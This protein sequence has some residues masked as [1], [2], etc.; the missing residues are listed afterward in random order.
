MIT[1][2]FLNV[3]IK[4]KRITHIFYLSWFRTVFVLPVQQIIFILDIFYLYLD[5]YLII[6]QLTLIILKYLIIYIV[7][8]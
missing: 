2:F 1:I 3:N 8:Q 6:C 4:S 5:T 7:Y